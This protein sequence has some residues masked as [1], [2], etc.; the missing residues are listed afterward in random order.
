MGAPSGTGPDARIGGVLR[1]YSGKIFLRFTKSAGT[2]DEVV[3][4]ANLIF[5]ASR[6]YKKVNLIL[7]SSLVQQWLTKPHFARYTLKNEILTI[8]NNLSN[9]KLDVNLIP[10]EQNTNA[11]S[12]DLINYCG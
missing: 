5:I 1:D 10:R 11:G 4:E 3:K 9:C 2:L 6:R 12:T 8:C 7:D